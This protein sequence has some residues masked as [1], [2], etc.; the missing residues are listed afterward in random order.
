M[1]GPNMI[2]AARRASAKKHASR[3]WTCICGKVCR[4]NGGISSHRSA[5]AV[6]ADAKATE[7]RP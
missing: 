1:S 3:V 7:C 5:C 4:G 6:L 2:S